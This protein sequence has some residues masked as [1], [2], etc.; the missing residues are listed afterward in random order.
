MARL[1]ELKAL[2][3]DQFAIYLQHDGKDHTL[4][5][6]GEKII[7]RLTEQELAKK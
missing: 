5:E 6:Y 7:P 4:A 3:V 2:G 1:D